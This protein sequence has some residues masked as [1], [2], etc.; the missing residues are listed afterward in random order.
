MNEQL[1]Q[2]IRQLISEFEADHAQAMASRP[3]FAYL[4]CKAALKSLDQELR[5]AVLADLK[6]WV[7]EAS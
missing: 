7:K 5:L 1:V 3:S 2:R 6:A 4:L